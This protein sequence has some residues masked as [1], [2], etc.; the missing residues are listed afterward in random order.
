MR[1][2]ASHAGETPLGGPKLARTPIGTPRQAQPSSSKLDASAAH[3]PH[4]AAKLW[5]P[6]S[7]V[8]AR[9][10]PTTGR[11]L[12]PTPLGL[13]SANKP[14]LLPSHMADAQGT[15]GGLLHMASHAVL[16]RMHKDMLY[17]NA[18]LGHSI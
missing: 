6:A 16:L 7:A 11:Q 2:K 10:E 14:A 5:A 3:V 17:K 9:S 8:G 1:T 18:M 12:A 4:T 13:A 15:P